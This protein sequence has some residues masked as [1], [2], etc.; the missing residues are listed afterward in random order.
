MSHTGVVA[1][2]PDL[3]SQIEL[4][5]SDVAKVNRLPED[6]DRERGLVLLTQ[7]MILKHR[8]CYACQVQLEG[9]G[10]ESTAIWK[11]AKTYDMQGFWGDMAV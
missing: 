11:L 9:A 5:E 2:T 6:Q 3:G 8:L 1:E 10:L 4:S 7:L